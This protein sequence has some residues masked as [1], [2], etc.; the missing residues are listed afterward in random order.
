MPPLDF[1][2]AVARF[3]SEATPGVCDTGRYRMPYFTWGDGPPL[4]FIHGVSDC[5]ESF[6][7][8]IARLSA[9]FR[10]VAYNL[11]G[12]RGDGA[13]LSR[14]NLATLVR[15]VWALLDHL[16]IDRGYVYGSSFG[17]AVALAAMRDQPRRLPRAILQGAIARRPLR[18]AER[19]L[20][21]LA[22]ILPGRMAGVPYRTKILTKVHGPP[23]AGRNEQVWRYFVDATGRTPI[24]T[25]GHQ[26][27]LVDQTDVRPWLADVKQPVLLVCGE[28]DPI[29]GRAQTEALMQ[30]LPNAGRVVIEGCGH[31][32]YYTHPEVLA[33]VVRQFLTPPN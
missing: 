29:V 30:G 20:T 1:A 7:Q 32:P 6:V 15:D 21:R 24:R 33:E 27:R 17:A 23:F 5:C 3:R 10:C 26:A 31:L 25:F 11:P 18:R 22:R 4:L 2:E 9:E 14:C 19:W 8:P 16:R 13:S 28:R 12:G